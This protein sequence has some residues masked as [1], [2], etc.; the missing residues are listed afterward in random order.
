MPYSPEPDMGSGVREDAREKRAEVSNG[1]AQLDHHMSRHSISAD[2]I[3]AFHTLR[4]SA[5]VVD[6][7]AISELAAALELWLNRLTATDGRLDDAG[8]SLIEAATETLG[9]WCE[10][11]GSD[12]AAQQ[13]A[14]LWL[15]QIESL[16][17]SV[18]RLHADDEA[19]QQIGRASCRE[20][21]SGRVD[22]GGRRIL[23]SKTIRSTEALCMLSLMTQ[24]RIHHIYL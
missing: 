1:R 16:Q 6:A 21:M 2:A 13:S 12:A 20:S 10:Q 15:E 3:R 19:R 9:S 23:K 11:V 4:G 8:I 17:G 18:D 7:S 5:R 22:R 14:R 24:T